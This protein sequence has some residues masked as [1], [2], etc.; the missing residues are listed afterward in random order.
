MLKSHSSHSQQKVS[1]HFRHWVMF[2][3][4]SSGALA[5]AAPP[6]DSGSAVR[7][8]SATDRALESR[9]SLLGNARGNA[10]GISS[11]S[12]AS[13]SSSSTAAQSNAS[14]SASSGDL[15]STSVSANSGAAVGGTTPGVMSDHSRRPEASF[16]L[17]ASA[18]RST[19]AN[20]RATANS[21]RDAARE[22]GRKG[23]ERA[24]ARTD[25]ASRSS[26]L[27]V[28]GQARAR[29]NVDHPSNAT[30]PE[31]Q[32]TTQ[33]GTARNA[34]RSRSGDRPQTTKSETAKQASLTVEHHG[35]GSQDQLMRAEAFLSHRLS[36][37]DRMR[38]A[39]LASGNTE[40]LRAADRLEV[41]A[42]SQFSQKTTGE[43]SVG[44]AMKNFNQ[45]A[46]P[47]TDDTAPENPG[48]DAAS[49][50][51]VENDAAIQ[52]TDPDLE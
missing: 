25:R 49:E 19:R 40:K 18:D 27:R 26:I 24:S 7:G 52:V 12:H 44:I 4:A 17:G 29:V 46:E 45:V 51:A 15:S 36:Q 39:A 42:R 50:V 5:Q 37:I 2:A 16:S 32:Q 23:L 34:G 8:H 14:G 21:A 38:D 6:I 11:A 30:T 3:I 1:R 35:K 31:E 20:L 47:S 9:A 28:K 13:G 33:D 43:H 22:N 41:L 48:V 10:G